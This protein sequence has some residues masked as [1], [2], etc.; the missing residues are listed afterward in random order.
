MHNGYGIKYIDPCNNNNNNGQYCKD[1]KKCMSYIDGNDNEYSINC[2]SVGF[3]TIISIVAFISIIIILIL[4]AFICIPLQ[5]RNCFR[6]SKELITDVNQQFE[7][8]VKS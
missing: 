7:V 2:F 8:L 1:I 3:M 6:Q 4:L 5:I